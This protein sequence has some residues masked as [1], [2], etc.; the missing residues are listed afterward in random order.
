MPRKNR[1]PFSWPPE[2][3]KLLGTAADSVVAKKLGIGA[4]T[5]TKKRHELDVPPFNSHRKSTKGRPRVNFDW[6]AEAIALLGTA[7]DPEIAQK[8]GLG[9]RAVADKRTKLGIDPFTPQQPLIELSPDLLRQLGKVTDATIAKKLGQT[10]AAIAWYRK[11]RGIEATIKRG[12]FPK[13][14]TELLGTA[15]DAEIAQRFGVSASTVCR[16]RNKLGISPYQLTGTGV[17]PLH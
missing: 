9:K 8:I 14:A 2:A 7:P 3:V 11:Q 16:H 13:E 17:P 5:V 10:D 4:M 15:S 12:T 1:P 6:T